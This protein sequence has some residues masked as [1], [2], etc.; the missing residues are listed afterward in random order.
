MSIITDVDAPPLLF[1]TAVSY[2]TELHQMLGLVFPQAPENTFNKVLSLYRAMVYQQ[3]YQFRHLV[4]KPRGIF[5]Q[6]L[7]R[8]CVL[9]QIPIYPMSDLFSIPSITIPTFLLVFAHLP[10]IAMYHLGI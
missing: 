8:S 10:V 2:S 3:I 6:V 5:C 4:K 9:A 7:P 1:P